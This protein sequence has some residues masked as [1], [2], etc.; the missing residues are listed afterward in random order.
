[1]FKGTVFY[2]CEFLTTN[3]IPHQVNLV[4]SFKLSFLVFQRG[5][6]SF[7]LIVSECLS[8]NCKTSLQERKLIYSAAGVLH[9]II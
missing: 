7:C 5:I 9:I 2:E 1:M 4:V 6:S 8:L 3:N